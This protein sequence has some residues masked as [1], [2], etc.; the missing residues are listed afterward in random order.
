MSSQ[1]VR[2]Q[3]GSHWDHEFDAF[4]DLAQRRYPNLDFDDI[5][6]EED[7]APSVPEIVGH[8]GVTGLEVPDSDV[9]GQ[10]VEDAAS[11]EIPS[12]GVLSQA[13]SQ[14]PLGDEAEI[15][16]LTAVEVSVG[17]LVNPGAVAAAVSEV[18]PVGHLE[19]GTAGSLVGEVIG[20]RGVEA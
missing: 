1:E 8:G 3:I 9:A 6:P 15:V 2:V 18:E 7:G 10:G 4:R 13:V 17:E 19:D 12:P 16:D 14:I 5:E 20:A 11:V